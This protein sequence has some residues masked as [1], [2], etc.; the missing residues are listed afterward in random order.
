MRAASITAPRE[1]T[2][3]PTAGPRRS[4]SQ[5]RGEAALIAS[6]APRPL[7]RG[8]SQDA[9]AGQRVVRRWLNDSMVHTMADNAES[10]EQRLAERLEHML[11]RPPQHARGG[12]FSVIGLMDDTPRAAAARR[13][14]R[15]GECAPAVAPLRRTEAPRVT[16][17]AVLAACWRRVD[18]ALRPLLLREARRQLDAESASVVGQG[19]SSAAH[20]SW[21][22][23]C[24][25][26]AARLLDGSLV[27]ALGERGAAAAPAASPGDTPLAGVLPWPVGPETRAA[28]SRPAVLAS[29]VDGAGAGIELVFADASSRLLLQ[30][31]A[32]FY[33][34]V[35]R[36]E[37]VAVDASE[38]SGS[39]S[40]EPTRGRAR[41]RQRGV[42]APDYE[43][44]L[45]IRAPHSASG[46]VEAPAGGSQLLSSPA[47]I[48]A[49][50]RVLE[51]E[52]SS[53]PSG[54]PSSASVPVPLIMVH[55]ASLR[56]D[57]ALHARRA[58][59]AAAKPAFSYGR[60]WQRQPLVAAEEPP[61]ATGPTTA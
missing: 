51:E 10:L 17:R 29:A 4:L 3:S 43:R 7:S 39:K 11:L 35:A 53:A 14:F 13:A 55:V 56:D 32:A 25:L 31:T 54:D 61:S 15:H 44:R 26:I 19:G 52:H 34:L 28:L 58:A 37:N 21:L 38:S 41:G 16:P 49:V 5:R 23:D 6:A 8:R 18:V 9:R 42:A 48:A 40:V 57:E 20:S 59:T 36:V 22:A 2:A 30:A 24:E 12:I 27:S 46:E 50:C 1:R 60:Q 47:A 33:G 45:I